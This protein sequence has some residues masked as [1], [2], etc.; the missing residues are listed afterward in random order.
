MYEEN[1]IKL[2]IWWL[3]AACGTLF[4]FLSVCLN[5]NLLSR[6]GNNIFID[7][8]NRATLNK[9]T[10]HEFMQ[11]PVFNVFIRYLL[12]DGLLSWYKLKEYLIGIR[13][14]RDFI[15]FD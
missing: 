9:K 7:P 4:R 15:T 3:V 13:G 10:R 14:V 8:G 5:L 12:Y 1:L 6:K 2:A 11:F